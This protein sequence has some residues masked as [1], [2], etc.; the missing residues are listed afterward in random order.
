M[1]TVELRRAWF[2]NACSIGA[3]EVLG[4]D[5]VGAERGVSA[6]AHTAIEEAGGLM[7]APP[8]AEAA[9]PSTMIQ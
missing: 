2:S 8:A 5:T 4:D 6:T 9:R 3:D 7:A 1:A